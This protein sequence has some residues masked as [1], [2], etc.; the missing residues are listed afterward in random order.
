M[1]PIDEIKD[2]AL[3]PVPNTKLHY[4]LSSCVTYKTNLKD[5]PWGRIYQGPIARDLELFTRKNDALLD[6]VKKYVERRFG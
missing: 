2:L 3:E 4:S 6:Y 5:V 1:Q